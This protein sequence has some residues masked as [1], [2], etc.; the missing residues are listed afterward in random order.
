[1]SQISSTTF[2]HSSPPAKLDKELESTA[3]VDT[4]LTD[5]TPQ[6]SMDEWAA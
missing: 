2:G 1:M 5:S 4:E 3:S 6:G